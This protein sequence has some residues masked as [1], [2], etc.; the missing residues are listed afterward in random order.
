MMCQAAVLNL[1]G[2]THLLL[3]IYLHHLTNK[4]SEGQRVKAT[5]SRS[6]RY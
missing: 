6:H 4:E 3:T 5:G 1:Q 2:L